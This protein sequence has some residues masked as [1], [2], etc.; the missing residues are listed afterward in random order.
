MKIVF[1]VSS[2]AIVYLMKF[3]TPIRETYDKKA[4]S[5]NIWFLIGPCAV[6]ALLIN[7]VFW[8]TEVHT[9]KH[10][11]SFSY[12]FTEVSSFTVQG[13]QFSSI[14]PPN[15]LTTWNNDH[16]Y[17]WI[18]Y[19]P[20]EFDA[21]DAAH[22]FEVK[23]CLWAESNWAWC[24]VEPQVEQ[25]ADSKRETILA[26]SIWWIMFRLLIYRLIAMPSPSGA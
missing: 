2:C 19:T 1:I 7:E 21:S 23:E 18:A 12:Y 4:D 24:E 17:R 15:Q 20:M 6:L 8:A 14:R 26:I 5:F 10:H 11:H 3:Q 9:G 22:R 16:L 13:K 25:M